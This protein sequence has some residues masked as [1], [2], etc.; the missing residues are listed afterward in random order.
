MV[1]L[2]REMDQVTVRKNFLVRHVAQ[3]DI[4]GTGSRNFGSRFVWWYPF[5]K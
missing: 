3:P 1:N 2:N 5:M 4:S